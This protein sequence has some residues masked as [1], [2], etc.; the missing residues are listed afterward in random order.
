MTLIF[1]FTFFFF[2]IFVTVFWLYSQQWWLITVLCI[3]TACN[4]DKWKK[5]PCKSDVRVLGIK[6]ILKRFHF[7]WRDVVLWYSLTFIGKYPRCKWDSRRCCQSGLLLLWLMASWCLKVA[8]SDCAALGS[9]ALVLPIRRKWVRAF[10]KEAKE[11][12][13]W[14]RAKISCRR[15]WGEE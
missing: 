11:A 4:F 5:A 3:Q 6:N 10:E 7:I 8:R 14:K 9:S 13:E 12:G 2:Y 15:M 1:F